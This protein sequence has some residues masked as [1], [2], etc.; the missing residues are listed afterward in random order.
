MVDATRLS[1]K[2]LTPTKQVK[3][4][5]K[6]TTILWCCISN[7]TILSN[8]YLRPLNIWKQTTTSCVFFWWKKQREKKAS[9]YTVKIH[10]RIPWTKW[11]KSWHRSFVSLSNTLAD[12]SSL[13]W[14]NCAIFYQVSFELEWYIYGWWMIFDCNNWIGFVGNNEI[15]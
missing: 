12:T 13:N 6:A 7:N 11:Q 5:E 3:A 15:T 14:S 10:P 2:E 4:R 9:Y 8:Q 1:S